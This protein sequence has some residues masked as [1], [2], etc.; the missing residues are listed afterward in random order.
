MLE[1]IDISNLVL[2]DLPP[3][4]TD[5]QHDLNEA[6]TGLWSA[7]LQAKNT[8][9]ATND[10][11]RKIRAMLGEQLSTMKQI[12]AKPGCDGQW[13]GFLRER[14]IPRASA[15]RLVARHLRSLDPSANCV[16]EDVSEPSDADVQKLFTSVW[17]KLKR[18]LRSQRSLDLF[19][20]L[21]T[22]HRQVCELTV[23]VNPMI[24][25]VTAIP[26]LPSSIK[27]STA[28]FDEALNDPMSDEVQFGF[29]FDAG[30]PW[31]EVG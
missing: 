10:E 7:H 24:A 19:I 5:S 8:A 27:A 23:Q 2:P 18:T 1:V 31:E 14:G 11:L 21:L 16:S 6:I 22:S 3:A 26:D 20:D 28:S 4:R 25:P 29:E 13:S 17:P 9:R 15:D 12:L 30:V